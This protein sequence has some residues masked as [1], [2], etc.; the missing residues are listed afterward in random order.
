M[1]L[2]QIPAETGLPSLAEEWR[3]RSDSNRRSYLEGSR[4][5][6]A[7]ALEIEPKGCEPEF[8]AP[9]IASVPANTTPAN[10]LA[11]DPAFWSHVDR[12]G[13]PDACWPYMGFRNKHGY[14]KVV[15]RV[16]GKPTTRI[17]ARHAFILSGGYIPEGYDVDHAVCD[18]P[19]CCNPAH[20]F[21]GTAMDNAADCAR[22][23]RAGRRGRVPKWSKGR[24]RMTPPSAESLAS[25]R[26]RRP[27][28]VG[29]PKNSSHCA[30][31]HE[32]TPENTQVVGTSRICRA[33]NA[34]RQ[35]R[36]YARQKQA[37]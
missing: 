31:G 19:P 24:D 14:G 9:T 28:P 26:P 33:C 22:K 29:R 23:G 1:N 13:G 32:Y 16:D 20:L 7:N 4:S 21:L 3:P 6:P 12:S 11:N 34:E 5:L 30:H 10:W 15:R 17:A 25:S 35:R 36:W 18:N 8:A 37:S 27:A 2:K